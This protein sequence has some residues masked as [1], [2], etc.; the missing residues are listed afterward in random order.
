MIQC[1]LLKS[2]TVLIS[3][4]LV[5]CS[6]TESDQDRVGKPI[7]ISL[8]PYV[9][10]LV[11]VN[12]RVGDDTLKLLL[13]TGGGETSITPDVAH[14]LGC[15]PSGRGVGFRMTGEMVEWQYCRGVSL[16]IGGLSFHH[17]R[18]GVWDINRLLPKGLPR[19][20]G[21]L[22]L[23]T[24]LNHPFTM[25]L[26]SRRLILETKK[27]LD[28]R[29]RT[30]T[31]LE[32]RIATGPAGS[33]LS[34]FLHGQVGEYAGWFLLDSGNLDAVLISQDLVK[35]RLGDSTAPADTWKSEVKLGSLSAGLARVRT[36]E[37]IY[38]G[39]LSE[40]FMRRWIF[41]F[42]L[43]ENAVWVS[44]VTKQPTKQSAV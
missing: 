27:S 36:K 33:E 9:G 7:E 38:D 23:K 15:V 19:L 22:S 39:A 8:N 44:P 31:R 14:R 29:V 20:D 41:T 12:A 1:R 32:S 37:I 17:E 6:A 34:V 25:D 18:I 40:E 28:R 43:S 3:I 35:S 10:R 30:M 16:S 5:A 24:F 21:I 2:L 42:D 13:D 4:S 11:T 26:S